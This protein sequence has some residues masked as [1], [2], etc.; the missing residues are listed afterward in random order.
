[1]GILAPVK[2]EPLKPLDA[3]RLKKL[4]SKEEAEG[5]KYSDAYR[6]IPEFVNSI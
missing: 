1:M 4:Y 6:Y 3:V 2:D 5:F